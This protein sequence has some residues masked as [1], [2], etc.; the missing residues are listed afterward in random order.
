M[1]MI[2]SKESIS[3]TP[4]GVGAD[5]LELRTDSVASDI[6]EFWDLWEEHKQVDGTVR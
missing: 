5:G 2:R 6:I 1:E 4:L 3:G